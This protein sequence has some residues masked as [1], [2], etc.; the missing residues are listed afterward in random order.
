MTDT[1]K[2]PRPLHS[3]R[4]TDTGGRVGRDER[5]NVILVRTRNDDEKELPVLK[6]LQFV[7]TVET[8]K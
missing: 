6:D 8:R 7:E 2:I 3:R 5:D 1:V 4:K